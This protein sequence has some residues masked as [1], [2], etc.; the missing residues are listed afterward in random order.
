M[1]AE[2][3]ELLK[4]ENLKQWEAGK[5][6]VYSELTREVQALFEARGDGIVYKNTIEREHE[7]ADSYI[8]FKDSQVK[9]AGFWGD[10]GNE[11]PDSRAPNGVR[12][13]IQPAKERGHVATTGRMT[14]VADSVKGRLQ[15]FYEQT[16]TTETNRAAADRLNALGLDEAFTQIMA[17]PLRDQAD[18][19][20]AHHL[21]L[22][23]QTGGQDTRAVAVR[24]HM[25]EQATDHARALWYISTIAKTPAE[26]LQQDAARITQQ[27]VADAGLSDELKKALADIERLTKEL[28]EQ[29]HGHATDVLTEIDKIIADA[30][31]LPAEERTRLKLKLREI[32][33][34]AT[35]P[36]MSTQA[37]DRL[38]GVLKAAGMKP[39]QARKLAERMIRDVQKRMQKALGTLLQT[40]GRVPQKQLPLPRTALEKLIA[41]NNAGKLDESAFHTAIAKA[42]GIPV[43]TPEMA[44]KIKALQREYDG[45]TNPE[46]KLAFGLEMMDV[47]HSL[48]PATLGAKAKA[49]QVLAMLFGR[50]LVAIR[51]ITGN[52]LMGGMNLA[53]D[54]LHA[55]VVS[56]TLSLVQRDADGA[57]VRTQSS[58]AVADRIAGLAQPWRDY[59]AGLQH[60]RDMGREGT[61]RDGLRVTLALAKLT[62]RGVLEMSDIKRGQASVFTSRT[63]RLIEDALTLQQ[64]VFDRA[65]WASAF[66]TS[67]RQQMDAA[68]SNGRQLLA[69]TAEM[70]TAAQL[71]A[72]R[73]IFTD[74]N[75]L[76]ACLKSAEKLLNGPRLKDGKFVF[77]RSY[78]LGS[79]TIAFA[80]IPGSI[81]VQGAVDFSPLG[82]LKLLPDIG[83]ALKG[84][85]LD[86]RRVNQIISRA[87]VGSVGLVGM[88]YYLAA[89]GIL[90][91]LPDDDKDREALRRKAGFG[92]YRI[93]VSALL[94]MALSGNVW[95]HQP[96]EHGDKILTYDWAQP[97]A[98]PLAMGAQAHAAQ[99]EAKLAGKRGKWTP[100][101]L[102]QAALGGVR[103]LESLP[104]LI[105]IQRLLSNVT[106]SGAAEGTAETIVA[107]PS[108]FVPGVFQDLNR[109]FD[110]TLRETRAG[111]L[112]ERELA[113]LKSRIPGLA[114][115]LP[116]KHD[117]LGDVQLRYQAGTNMFLNVYLSPATQSRFRNDPAI[118]EIDRLYEATAERGVI[119]SVVRARTMKVNGKDL[120]LTNEQISQMQRYVGL[121]SM[122]SIRK[123]MAKPGYARMSDRDAGAVFA[124]IISDT[125]AAAKIDI[126]GQDSLRS[127]PEA[128]P[129]AQPRVYGQ[130]KVARTLGLLPA[131]K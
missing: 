105:G 111:N 72:N 118:R 50:P 1:E 29:R 102:W 124:N 110:N 57:R 68:A 21:A 123:E 125:A 48:V 74:D 131:A 42:F 60:A 44:A 80:K 115:T 13:S 71:E 47:M 32:L 6:A 120:E 101:I 93:N 122:E 116:P 18:M 52:L 43:F 54:G 88:G 90:T 37:R 66:Q 114:Q 5:D 67:I 108:N 126:L 69:P 107:M 49:V 109:F 83:H 16:T 94:R 46:V 15:S 100:P 96:P 91:A 23:L 36:E 127:T 78:G 62:S 103:S 53:A 9:R 59:Q 31:N 11:S 75:W 28:A 40:L 99:E 77:D 39:D 8:T 84:Q 87:T 129:S 33:S 56:P 26:K 112:A 58:L 98:I 30:T 63:M 27:A 81:G 130:Q 24:T 85:P 10:A 95:T 117:L 92:G 104:M 97:L 61:W 55:W 20:L 51:N 4:R 22:R 45:A 35:S 38:T 76:S 89:L 2:N 113:K 70:V 14:E 19:A 25:A 73:A 64:G 65:F 106:Y 86:H 128:R 82:F 3:P 121:V 17:S 119:P 41:L 12:Y 79:A 7:G 34:S